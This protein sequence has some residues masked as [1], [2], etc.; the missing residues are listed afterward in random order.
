M[1]VV[2]QW[3]D[4]DGECFRMSFKGGGKAS[5]SLK[6][7]CVLKSAPPPDKQKNGQMLQKSICNH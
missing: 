4:M 6:I 2:G 1:A 3:G 5:K 7:E